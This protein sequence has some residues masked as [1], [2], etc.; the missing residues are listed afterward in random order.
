MMWAMFYINQLL[1]MEDDLF[2][3]KPHVHSELS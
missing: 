2:E 1:K 3:E